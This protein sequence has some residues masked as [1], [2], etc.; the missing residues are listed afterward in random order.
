MWCQLTNHST[1]MHSYA[2]SQLEGVHFLADWILCRA[3]SCA[4]AS[5]DGQVSPHKLRSAGK[6]R[7]SAYV[8]LQ[9]TGPNRHVEGCAVAHY[10]WCQLQWTLFEKLTYDTSRWTSAQHIA[11]VTVAHASC[12]CYDSNRRRSGNKRLDSHKAWRQL[13]RSQPAHPP[14]T[15]SVCTHL[16]VS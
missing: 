1:C 8:L 3:P 7:T 12:V 2:A 6:K 5:V 14:H 15:R 13:R 9:R 16:Y 4:S 10:P 11:D